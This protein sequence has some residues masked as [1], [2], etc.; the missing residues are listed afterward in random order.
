M[1]I[2]ENF[3][4]DLKQGMH[5]IF[6]DLGVKIPI[7]RNLD[8]MLLDYLTINKKVIHFKKRDVL[9]NPELE[10]KLLTH[11]KRNEVAEIRKRLIAG[12]NVNFFQSKRLFET[13][14]HDHLL[15]EWN[16]FHFHLTN[17]LE[18]GS[19][20]VKRTNQLLFAY[21]DDTTAILLDIENHSDGIFADAKWLE[22]L[23]NHFPHVLEPYLAVDLVDVNPKVN[24]VERQTLWNK[25][26][27][28]GMTPVNGKV[29]HSPG[30]GRTTSGHSMLVTKMSGEILRW[31][32][33]VTEQFESRLNEICQAYNFEPDKV[34]FGLRF[35]NITLEA[36]EKKSNT[37]LLTYPY[38]FNFNN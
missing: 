19:K 17:Q 18:K 20:F 4:D 28:I 33:D 23:D 30:I 32:F 9:I 14:F 2:R 26:Y 7:K 1:T 29:F 13:K 12:R 10:A 15:Y 35:G 34:N 38:R 5:L 37:I 25:G 27:T 22:I 31:L 36:I 3:E 8:S 11:S 6:S 16:I 21:I 24:S